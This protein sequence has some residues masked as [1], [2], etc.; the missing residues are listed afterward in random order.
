MIDSVSINAA[1]DA[2]DA[3]QVIGTENMAQVQEKIG[4]FEQYMRELPTK[5]LNLGIRVIF[6]VLVLFIGAQI[7]KL[8]RKILKRSLEKASADT[9][10]IQFLDSLAKVILY[11]LLILMIGTS[12]GLDAA[13][14]VAVVGSCGVALGLALQGSLSNFAGGV[15]ILLLK[16]FKVGDYIIE[17]NKGNEGTVVEIQLFYTKLATADERIVVLPN[18]PLANCSLTNVTSTY[19]R[20]ATFKVGI[21]YGADHLKAL[22]IMRE[23][24]LNDDLVLKDKDITTFVD[25]LSDSAVVLGVHCY[26]ANENFWTVKG[27]ILGEIKLAFD[28][29]GISIPYPQIDVHMKENGS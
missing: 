11:T 27:R 9:G 8:L 17:D 7:I 13:S 20:R 26:I 19:C 6:A 2:I 25:D 4:V 16:P 5:A 23:V 29:A 15:L 21:S 12:F 10:V 28:R 1:L 3:E 18:G 22:Q 14:V 24:V